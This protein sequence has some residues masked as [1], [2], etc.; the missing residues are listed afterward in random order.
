M[1]CPAQVELRRSMYSAL[2]VCDPRV[3]GLLSENTHEVFSWLI[4]KN[5]GLLS[6]QTMFEFWRISGEHICK[7]YLQVCKS[8]TGIG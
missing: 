7:M 2:H 4:G 1:Q 8:R 3:E 6:A 5:I